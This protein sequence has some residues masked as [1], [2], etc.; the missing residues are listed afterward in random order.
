VD[1][2]ARHYRKLVLREGCAI[3]AIV[4]GTPSLFDGIIDAVQAGRDLSG[5]LPAIEHGDW[6]ALASEDQE[7]ADDAL[8]VSSVV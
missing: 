8:T 2:H 6:S 4:I 1:H 5:Q 7:V 3:G